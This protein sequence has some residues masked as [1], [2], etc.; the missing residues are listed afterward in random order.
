M[1]YIKG[2]VNPERFRGSSIGTG[3]A[4]PRDVGLGLSQGAMV[5]F[6]AQSSSDLASVISK[7]FD[8]EYFETLRLDERRLG[9]THQ[10]GRGQPPAHWG[11][12]PG[13]S[14]EIRGQLRSSDCKIQRTALFAGRSWI[15]LSSQGYGILST[16]E[17]GNR[18]PQE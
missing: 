2:L 11:L 7:F 15:C 18:L 14:S 5:A 13:Q 1:R 4:A 10:G 6:L 17:S 9:R 8:S 3:R 16:S 12:R